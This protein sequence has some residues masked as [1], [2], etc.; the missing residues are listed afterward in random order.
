[1]LS[2]K[3]WV[4]LLALLSLAGFAACASVSPQPDPDPGTDP[5]VVAPPPRPPAVRSVAEHGI[6]IV[7]LRLTA[8]GRVLD[9][10]YRVTDAALAA[11]LL[12]RRTEVNGLDQAT[13]TVLPVPRSV[14]IGAMRQ[15]AVEPQPGR[16]YF[17]FFGNTGRLVR[18]GSLVTA[19]FG[20]VEIRDLVVE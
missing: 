17:V 13:G 5:R 16:I 19:R 6:E 18:R 9:L 8:G 12:D 3:S 4:R 11:P 20:A 10:R 7:A 15:S 1:M 2:P 14:K